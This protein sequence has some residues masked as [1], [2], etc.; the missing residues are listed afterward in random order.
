MFSNI[1]VPT[2]GSP[3]ALSAVE[4][5]IEFARD[6]N[7]TITFVTVIEPFQIFSFDPDQ[8]G[9]TRED[10][11][12]L[13]DMQAAQFLT[14]A[15]MKARKA[16][17]A[18]HTVKVESDSVHSVIVETAIARGC[19]LIA[20]ASHGRSGVGALVLGSVTAKVLSHSRI[21]VLVYR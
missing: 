4:K 16:G 14:A 9:A 13:A 20:M 21:P 17:V 11:G 19:D 8:L 3:L 2:D 12:R 6:A 1:L 10:Y 15:E 18:C 7:A 5:A